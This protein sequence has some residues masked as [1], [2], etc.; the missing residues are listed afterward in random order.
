MGQNQER[1]DNVQFEFLSA[2]DEPVASRGTVIVRQDEMVLEVEDPD[3]RP[4]LIKGKRRQGF[5]AG[6]HEGLPG[7]V[8]V[9]AKWT[10]LDDIFIG[11]WLQKGIDYVFMFRLPEV[12]ETE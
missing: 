12:S 7:D 4:Y 5:W 9:E 2:G 11:T 6:R 3:E 1:H 8:P 10:R